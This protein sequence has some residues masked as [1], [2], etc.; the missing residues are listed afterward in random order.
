MIWTIPNIITVV[1]ILIAPMVT[2]L[3]FLEGYQPKLVAFVLFNIA[4]FSDLV[5]GYLARR[6]GSVTDI[7][8]EL[9]PLADKLLLFCTLIPIYLL[10]RQAPEQYQ[11]PWWNGLP[12]W[13]LVVLVGRELTMMILRRIAAGR[14]VAIAAITVGKVK[15]VVQNI[16]LGG[17]ILWF[18]WRDASLELVWREGWFGA[19]WNPFH[20]T[21]M[22]VTLAIALVLTVYS[23][24]VYLFRFRAVFLGGSTGGHGP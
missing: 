5:D 11:I 19:F 14:G 21:V 22:A 15:A 13:V 17:T 1:R 6:E 3:M 4:A 7:G 8:K 10:M 18:T 20:G 2:F 24:G 9:D 16:F 23:F 12:M